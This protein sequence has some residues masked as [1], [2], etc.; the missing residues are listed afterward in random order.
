MTGWVALLALAVPAALFSKRYQWWRKPVPDRYPRVLMYHMVRDHV[1]GSASNKLRVAPAMFERQI[2]WLAE[3]GYHFALM[4]EL[5][6]PEALPPRTVALTFDDGFADN[7]LNADPV[8]EKFNARAT[9]YLVQ[10]RHGRDWSVYKKAHH[11]SGELMREPK[12]DDDQV[13][14]MLASGRWELGGHTVTHANLSKLTEDEKRREIGDSKRALEAQFQTR[15]SS[16]AYP[17]GIYDPMDVRIAE[18]AGFDT[19]TTTV[20][21]IDTDPD[22]RRFELKRIKMSGKDTWLAFRLRMRSGRR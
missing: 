16:F 2:R 11:N 22:G 10:D 1:P 20:E 13:E 15:L 8:L 19:A 12:L 18:E 3:N 14:R 9:L 4:S 21:G 17:F 6:R 7:L 5:T